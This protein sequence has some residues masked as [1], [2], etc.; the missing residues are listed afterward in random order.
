MDCT[1]TCECCGTRGKL[2]EAMDGQCESCAGYV[3]RA[4]YAQLLA[5]HDD[6]PYDRVLCWACAIRNFW[7]A[8]VQVVMLTDPEE[9]DPIKPCP[10]CGE[11]PRYGWDDPYTREEHRNCWMIQ[12]E[13][14]R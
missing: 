7:D 10:G 14:D 5:D 8:A 4:C 1:E 9:Y 13:G 6:A 3:C 12:H 2:Y 11:T